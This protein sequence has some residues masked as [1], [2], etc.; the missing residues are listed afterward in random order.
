MIGI[1]QLLSHMA[2]V[3]HP[4]RLL[5]DHGDERKPTSPYQPT[6]ADRDLD[7]Q[8]TRLEAEAPPAVAEFRPQV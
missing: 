4:D 8:L 7:A 5:E 3:S 2:Y 1:P 6:P